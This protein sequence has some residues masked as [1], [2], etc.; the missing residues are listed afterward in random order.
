M[1]KP[2]LYLF[3]AV[4]AL[5]SFA[6]CAS[7]DS[8]D[9]G[10]LAGTGNMEL[11]FDHTFKGDKLIL[12]VSS[13]TN[14]QMETLSISRFNY[15]ISNISLIDDRGAVIDYPKEMGYFIVDS[16]KSQFTIQLKAIPS[17]NYKKIRFGLGVDQKRYLEGEQEQQA[18]WDLAALHNMTWSWITGYKFINLEGVFRTADSAEKRE[19]KIH[20]G[21]HGK[22]LDNYREL[23]LDFPSTARVRADLK[24]NVHFLVD[25]NLILD[26]IH[27]LKLTEALNPTG[28]TAV[29]M[30]SAEKAP[31]IMENATKMFVID[32]VHNDGQSHAN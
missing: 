26:G 1:R 17:G 9:H 4:I 14:S 10:A 21:S 32:H 24:P 22:A 7:D 28:T 30:V 20:I 2:I 11:F 19:F 16:E 31:K 15:I 23:E 29:I 5:L 27:K 12:E 8:A 13:H 18:F 6:S 3:A 25:G